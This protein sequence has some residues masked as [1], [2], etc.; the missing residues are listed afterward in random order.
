[1]RRA[2]S[3]M[4]TL[5]SI[6]VQRGAASMRAVEDAIARQVLHGGDLPTNLLELGAV[7]EPM[8]NI[9]LSESFNLDPAPA[10]RLPPPPEQVLRVIPGD[11]ALRHGV[12]P[13]ELRDRTLV[14]AT[15]E[16]LSN[17]VEDDL[18]FALDVSIKQLAAPLV[19]VRQA[20]AEH[21]GIALDRRLSRLVAKLEGHHDP[22]PSTVPPAA[23]LFPV[24]PVRPIS[25]PVPSF[26]TGVPLGDPDEERLAASSPSRA[27]IPMSV[28]LPE[29]LIPRGFDPSSPEPVHHG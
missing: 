13:L 10:G 11:L 20:I 16:P 15:A 21:Y 19:R 26:G 27:T 5:S 29:G 2:S 23:D 4:P 3:A 22:S 24:K 25:I 8:L 1:M 18:G 7:S 9:V 14:L 17:V 28:P 12:F 6:L